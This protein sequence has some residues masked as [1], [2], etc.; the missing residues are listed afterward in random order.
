MWMGY[1][2]TMYDSK[3]DSPFFVRRMIATHSP[4]EADRIEINL[5]NFSLFLRS[6]YYFERKK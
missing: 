4:V 1:G 6:I 2:L 5:V 3:Y